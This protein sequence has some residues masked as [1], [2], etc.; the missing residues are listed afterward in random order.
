MDELT[1]A[2]AQRRFASR[3]S[4]AARIAARAKSPSSVD[5]RTHP[6]LTAAR[7]PGI[8]FAGCRVGGAHCDDR[9]RA[10]HLDLTLLLTK[11]RVGL[12]SK[13]R[14]PRH[15]F[16]AYFC[17]PSSV[18]RFLK[19]DSNL[20]DP[21]LPAPQFS[22][23]TRLDSAPPMPPLE[24]RTDPRDELNLRKAPNTNADSLRVPAGQ[25]AKICVLD[26]FDGT[27]LAG[28]ALTWYRIEMLEP[29]S[30]TVK[31]LSDGPSPRTNLPTG[32]KVWGAAGGVK[33]AA[34]P[35]AAFR[36][37]LREWEAAEPL[38]S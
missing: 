2:I 19:P 28:K 5:T 10:P 38:M 17:L 31:S 20:T 18:N 30:V 35:W 37:D 6:R 29:L 23:P 27:D 34:A 11:P 7:N 26:K 33:I 1:V 16:L 12:P 14:A 4:P 25:E 13:P 8:Q 36:R 15:L 9:L 32:T 3:D 21:L 24:G 22:I